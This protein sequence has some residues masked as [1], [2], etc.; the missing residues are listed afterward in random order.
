M[1]YVSSCDAGASISAHVAEVANFLP[2]FFTSV[3]AE[4]RLYLAN[5][6]TEFQKAP[7]GGT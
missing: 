6:M 4:W 3:T 2:F 1:C 5:K 7:V